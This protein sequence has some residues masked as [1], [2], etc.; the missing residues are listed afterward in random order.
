MAVYCRNCGASMS[1]EVRY[2]AACGA[3]APA[4]PTAY[5]RTVNSPLV[6]PRVGRMI[7][8]VCQGLANQYRWDPVWVRVVAVITALFGGGLGAIAYIVM[9]IVVPEEPLM[10]PASTPYT[11][12]QPPYRA[13]NGN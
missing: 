12:P 1:D 9:W 11:Q 6:R 7:G 8:G 13:P 4:P 5:T 2:C 3:A 10:L